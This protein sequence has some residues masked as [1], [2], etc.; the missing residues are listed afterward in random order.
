MFFQKLFSKSS[1][2]LND[3]CSMQH[4]QPLPS[5][6]SDS[7]STVLSHSL[8]TVGSWRKSAPTLCGHFWHQ[9]RWTWTKRSGR[10]AL[11]ARVSV[12]IVYS[13]FVYTGL[14][15]ISMFF[16]QGSSPGRCWVYQ[17]RPIKHLA[18]NFKPLKGTVLQKVF[19]LSYATNWF[20]IFLSSIKMLEFFEKE[21]CHS[22]VVNPVSS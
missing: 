2:L 7:S 8:C 22:F 19:F 3:L 13:M 21:N 17:G 6:L 18:S 1:L 14:V 11:H 20:Y 10:G 12:Y 5:L 16:V 15:Y 9:S 4:R